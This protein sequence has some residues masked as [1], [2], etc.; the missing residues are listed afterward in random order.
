MW[1]GVLPVWLA[2]VLACV[3]ASAGA[4][5]TWERSFGTNVGGSGVGVC[6]V[7]AACQNGSNTDPRG[8]AFNYPGDTAVDADGNIYVADSF[9]DRVAK[10]TPEGVFLRAWGWGVDKDRP[11]QF[12]V[13]TV[14]ADCRAGDRV[15]DGGS[16]SG[17]GG[18]AVSPA[19][20]VYVAETD[21]NRLSVF[22]T[23]GS[24]R[25]VVGEGVATGAAV[26]ERC[27]VASSCRR[28][29]G[30]GVAGSFSFPRGLAFD[31]TGSYWVG[32]VGGARVQKLDAF[33]GFTLMVGKD[34]GGPGLGRCTLAALCG[35]ATG[36][37]QRGGEFV[38]ADG[39]TV[40]DDD[41]VFIADSARNRITALESDGAFFQAFGKDVQGPG[42]AVCNH[43]PSCT[44]GQQGTEAG[45]FAGPVDVTADTAGNLYVSE[46]YSYRVQILTWQGAFRAILGAGV[47]RDA[48]GASVCEIAARCRAGSPGSKGGE[49]GQPWGLA[50]SPLGVLHV[51]DPGAT[52][53]STFR[54]PIPPPRPVIT[55]VDPGSPA[56]QNTPRVRGRT[57]RGT[58][59]R[60]YRGLGCSGAPIAEGTPEEFG[61]GLLV[62]VA[63]DTTT[64]FTA[65]ALAAGVPSE[66]TPGFTYV[67]DSTPPAPPTVTG[68]SPSSP[69]ND[70][71]P[72]V[73]GSAEAGSSVWVFT[74]PEC[75]GGAGATGSAADFASP[76]FVVG[77][78]PGDQAFFALAIDQAG[79]VSACSPGL[80]YT[81][82][83]S[84]VVATG[85]GAPEPDT[86][87]T[88]GP[89]ARTWLTTP[90]FE[91]R[92][93]TPG[94]KFRC[95]M[96][97]GA[98]AACDGGSYTAARLPAGPHVFEAAAIG[99]G[100]VVDP[101][102]AR[103]DFVVT[104][105]PEQ[106]DAS[107]RVD[108]F[109][110]PTGGTSRLGC[111]WRPVCAER[112]TCGPPMDACPVGAVCTLS[113]RA[114]FATPLDRF[115]LVNLGMDVARLGSWRVQAAVGFSAT[116]TCS[117]S[118][119][120]ASTT[121]CAASVETRFI[122][123]GRPVGAFCGV[124]ALNSLSSRLELGPDDYGPND[125]RRLQCEAKL[126]ISSASPLDA[127]TAG[128][129]VG[130]YA[131]RPGTAAISGML[132]PEAR[133]AAAAETPAFRSTRRRVSAA[134]PVSLRPTLSR[135]ARRILAR[136]NRV[137]VRMRA[138][139]TSDDGPR[140]ARTQTITLTSPVNERARQRSAFRRLCRTNAKARKTE[141]CR[142]VR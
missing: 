56:N 117:L 3:P 79:N 71:S 38:G 99:A 33:D 82:T 115:L 1:R 134:G 102:P 41:M 73:F 14:A 81:Y 86:T 74:N 11:G 61:F 116:G 100:N 96:D 63:D 105:A 2:L 114:D 24:F 28:G 127:V 23:N 21:A 51:G 87:I 54:N 91:F 60:I 77:V 78:P 65:R 49:F 46:L 40:G 5:P 112:V 59:V 101:T 64:Q 69:A 139:F 31:A 140:I 108:P 121:A 133:A 32:E 132:V 118:L 125:Q 27:T 106:R 80:P 10:F 129:T 29:G 12:G 104:T 109:V 88:T 43:A 53:V 119:L 122:G 75:R 34:V 128:S 6:T 19:G 89:D 55:G 66:C 39:L 90:R 57:L 138:T 126:R 113:L 135:A 130:L 111:G 142:R 30:T 120:S 17:P 85:P 35:F 15:P 76:G 20:E 50:V 83:G 18:I 98:W 9:W 136:R 8:D 26:L 25:R 103:R 4:A 36:G 52:R 7:A 137:R 84:V 94:A 92:S 22:D 44:A 58:T 131:P 47:D 107:C 68:T 124:T 16:L 72:R 95:R 97:G 67:E 62:T 13:C 70:P 123:A 141:Q 48:P 93:D 45:A 42:T 110:G 37:G